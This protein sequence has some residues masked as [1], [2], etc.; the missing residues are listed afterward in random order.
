MRKRKSRRSVSKS[1]S[2]PE[3]TSSLADD[4]YANEHM[5]TCRHSAAEIARLLRVYKQQYTL[6]S[7]SHSVKVPARWMSRTQL[8]IID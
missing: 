3:D 2:S 1:A 7:F 6:V 4:E 8:T 5:A